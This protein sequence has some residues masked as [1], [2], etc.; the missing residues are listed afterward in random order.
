MAKWHV[1]R[2]QQGW[3]DDLARD[4]YLAQQCTRTAL[5]ADPAN[6]LA[7]VMDGF[8]HT[9]LLKD[10]D[11]AEQRY[12]SALEHLPNDPL[13][14]LLRGTLY[15]FRGQGAAAVRDTEHARLLTPLDPPRFFFDSLA[16]SA[17]IAAEDYA[18]A[19]DLAQQSLPATRPPPSPL[20]VQAGAPTRRRP[21]H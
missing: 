4:A 6:A 12:D 21:T 14:R 7:L 1:L 20:R 16:A 8:V 2:V 15:A 11:V 5:D 13:G 18:R 9:N 19:P 17:C 10:L 3:S